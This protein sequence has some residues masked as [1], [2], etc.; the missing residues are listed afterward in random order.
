M[1]RK[2]SLRLSAKDWQRLSPLVDEA[3][4]LGPA[5]RERWLARLDDL[6]PELLA[7]LRQL[8]AQHSAP[9]TESFLEPLPTTRRDALQPYVSDWQA[10]DVVGNY[11]LLRS[12]GMGGMGEVWLAKRSDGAY[13]RSVALKLPNTDGA[14][15][16]I[17]ER[18]LR[19]R[20]VLASLEHAHIARFYDAGVTTSGQ[21]FLAMEYVEG[22]TL[23]AYADARKLATRERCKLMLQVLSAVQFAHQRL[24]VHRDLKPS[25]IMVRANGDV[26]LLD[27]GIAKVLD[28]TTAHGNES[29]LTRD[30]GRAL[31]LAY[32]APEQVL[33][34]P[35]STATDV[36]AAGVLMYELLSGH[37]P[38]AA[39]EKTMSSM[40]KAYDAPLRPMP[41]DRGRDLNAI[42]AR[43]LR[44][45]PNDRYESAAAFA[46]DIKRYLDDQP[47]LAVQGARWYAISK[48]VARQKWAVLASVAGVTAA[49]TLG[50]TA[51]LQ[52]ESAR[53]NSVAMKTVQR[54]ADGLLSGI[55]PDNAETQQFTAK[56]LLDRSRDAL[57][58]Q[59]LQP[60]LALKFG[61]VYRMIGEPQQSIIVIDQALANADGARDRDGY[62][63][64][65]AYKA[66]AQSDAGDIDAAKATVSKARV[67]SGVPSQSS[68]VRSNDAALAILSSVEGNVALFANDIDAAD[69]A[70]G[71]SRS[72]FEA[73]G[74]NVDDLLTYA[75]SQ[76]SSIAH[77]RGDLPRALALL[78]E[79]SAAAT[80][81]GERGRSAALQRMQAEGF[82]LLD[83]GDPMG[84]VRVLRECDE[85]SVKR[86][87]VD[88]PD[89]LAATLAHATALLES[90]EAEAAA[91]VYRAVAE[92]ATKARWDIRRDALFL[93]S[94]LP[95]RTDSDAGTRLLKQMLTWR[96]EGS[97]DRKL[98]GAERSS[99]QRRLGELS[100]ATG[101]AA[102]AIQWLKDAELSLDAASAAPTMAN[103]KIWTVHAVAS[104]RLKDFAGARSLLD[105]ARPIFVKNL[106]AENPRVVAIDLYLGVVSA[107]TGDERSRSLL[108][109]A[110]NE[111]FKR[112]QTAYT[113]P[114]RLLSLGQWIAES[115]PPNWASLP[116]F[117]P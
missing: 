13:Q 67:V 96:D 85:Q 14:P 9:E 68:L 50:T 99:A 39:D 52:Y 77:I 87:V 108:T 10:N 45:A 110:I 58:N 4:D 54:L 20:D 103:A 81:F 21:P 61:E 28:E 5:A 1:M 33:A 92:V 51:M 115:G 37:R 17:R 117:V 107:A 109:S 74:S 53:E 83:L 15:A 22:D 65:L 47:V 8:I 71:N 102:D 76:Q 88:Y 98:D 29:Q 55:S 18:M 66:L 91:R 64:L 41:M 27:F 63:K 84:A 57:S 31:T 23:I 62:V 30:T 26:A 6:P 7:T 49:L 69:A 73:I 95:N 78:K 100:L 89:R 38:F 3:L 44:R 111:P 93:E 40:I 11:T 79:A 25:N 86:F 80:R 48:F 46:D 105:K 97:A 19:E 35:I 114:K 106:G 59:P 56:Q 104:I 75:I 2:R 32:A 16:K 42:V 113:A 116:A 24:V 43:A 12:I 72:R 36:F 101:R 70:Y 34:E 112:L 82:F 90:G 94:L 60:E